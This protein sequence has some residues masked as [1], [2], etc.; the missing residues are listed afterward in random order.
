MNIY[1]DFTTIKESKRGDFGNPITAA[2]Y[3]ITKAV[4]KSSHKL[5]KTSENADLVFVFG[6]ITDRKLE[7]E[8]A[9]SIL[10]HRCEG[11]IIMSLD[12]SMFSTYIRRFLGTTETFMF[13][14]GKNDCTGEG[15]FLNENSTKERFEKFKSNFGFSE[16]E[17]Q[18]DNTKPILFA[19]QS[20]KGWTYNEKKPY[21]ERAREIIQQLR[22]CTDREII[23]KPHPNTDRYP[24]E[25]ISRGFENITILRQDRSRRD[26]IDDLKGCG[27][28]VTHSSSSSCES[29]VEGI[30]TFVLDKRGLSYDYFENDFT[31]INNLERVDWSKRQQL[32][33]DWANTSWHV[34]ELE[35]PLL[36]EHYVEKAITKL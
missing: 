35:N 17:P 2:F 4:Q 21:F 31:N 25:W 36:L 1:L 7:T 34:K 24:V 13:R 6:S 5:V 15:D 8:R 19:L 28:F 20:E 11:K 10:K 16:R 30:P 26:I 22:E 32:L 23:L 29:F 14:I 27:A 9:K 3:S 12:S 18:C 33:Y